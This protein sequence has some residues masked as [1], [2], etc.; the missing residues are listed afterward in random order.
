MRTM[1]LI[2][3]VTLLAGCGERADEAPLLVERPY[4]ESRLQLSPELNGKRVS[5]DG[6]IHLDNGPNGAAIAMLYTL[7]SAPRGQGDDLVTFEGERGEGPNQIDLPVLERTEMPVNAGGEIL[8]VDLASARYQDSTGAAHP[9]RDKVRVTGRLRSGA[10]VED[11]R[12]P[13]GQRYRS[14]LTDVTLERAP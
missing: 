9:L 11:A 13:E 5:V 7:N 6:Y 1:I 4:V 14:R 3:A 2:G 12:A 8:T 10:P